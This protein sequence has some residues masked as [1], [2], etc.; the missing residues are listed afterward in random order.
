MPVPEGATSCLCWTQH[1]VAADSFLCVMEKRLQQ[2]WR[3]GVE[4]NCTVW[5]LV[6]TSLKSKAEVCTRS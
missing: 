5:E 3:S 4:A 6:L 1:R 2:E